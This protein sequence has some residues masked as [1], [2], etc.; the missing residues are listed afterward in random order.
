MLFSTSRKRGGYRMQ[1]VSGTGAGARF[2][3]V[4]KPF[5]LIEA[6]LHLLGQMDESLALQDF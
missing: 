4:E 1:G 5:D 2:G 6:Q 3:G